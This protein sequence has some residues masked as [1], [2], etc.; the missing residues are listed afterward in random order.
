MTKENNKVDINKHEMDIVTL[1][2]QNVNDLLSIKELY[3]KIEELGEKITQIKYIDNT[4][5]K[6]LKKEYEN[7]KKIILDENIQAQLNNKI[8]E[9]NL[10]LTHDVETINSQLDTKVNKKELVVSVKDFGAKGDGKTDDSIAF[11]SA[12]SYVATETNACLYIPAGNYVITQQITQWFSYAP[13]IY[14]DGIDKT[15]IVPSSKLVEGEYVFKFHGKEFSGGCITGLRL[16]DFTID[17]KNS[18]AHAI[19][20]SSLHDMNKIDTISIKNVFGHA[21]HIISKYSSDSQTYNCSEALVIDNSQFK[22]RKYIANKESNYSLLKAGNGETYSKMVNEIIIINSRFYG[23]EFT[24]I[25]GTDMLLNKRSAIELA[26]YSVGWSI[27]DCMFNT[28]YGAPVIKIG[29]NSGE[30]VSRG[31]RIFSNCFENCGS[32]GDFED[33]IN[34][35]QQNCLIFIKGADYQNLNQI[36]FNRYEGTI[37]HKY[38]YVIS[39]SGNTIFENGMNATDIYSSSGSNQIITFG[40]FNRDTS[41]TIGNQYKNAIL[42]TFGEYIT[43]SSK[44]MVCSRSDVKSGNGINQDFK[45]MLLFGSNISETNMSKTCGFKMINEYYEKPKLAYVVN[46]QTYHTFLE[47][48][49]IQLKNLKENPPSPNNSLALVNGELKFKNSEGVWKTIQMV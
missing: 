39:C 38:K 42:S 40:N 48:G 33:N 5:V 24:K 30:F 6:K 1:K 32:H 26:T 28:I 17:M 18:Y 7:L 25:T 37:N 15:K 49:S 31:H 2:K 41:T 36:F 21:L 20:L 34:Y 10:K 4:L 16:C 43:C 3:S 13:K 9:F 35:I 23:Q 45:P 47:D 46:E 22:G 27:H 44:L 19:Q 8:G 14:G 11:S 12:L 29:S